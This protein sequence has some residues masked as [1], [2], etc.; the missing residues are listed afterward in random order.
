MEKQAQEPQ[1]SQRLQW[2]IFHLKK[3]TTHIATLFHQNFW[4]DSWTES[5]NA[6]KAFQ[7]FTLLK[8]GGNF[9]S[10]AFSLLD[11]VKH[12][13]VLPLT[14][15]LLKYYSLKKTKIP[16]LDSASC[17]LVCQGCHPPARCRAP[18]PGGVQQP[19][20]HTA[21]RQL[22]CCS[23]ISWWVAAVLRSGVWR[24]ANSSGVLFQNITL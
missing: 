2:N 7:F 3:E 9:R 4:A 1:A 12:R 14:L 19:S 21:E 17:R 22:G 6:A 20:S 13:M 23:S 16:P 15:C 24:Q 18:Q 5:K 10:K 11:P 8:Q